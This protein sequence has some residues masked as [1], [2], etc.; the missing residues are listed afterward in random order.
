[1]DTRGGIWRMVVAMCMS[2]TIGFFVLKSGQAVGTVVF[3]RCLIGALGLLTWLA[4]GRGFKPLTARDI[5]WIIAGGIALILNWFCLF[6]AYR[7]SSISIATVVYHVQPFFLILLVALFQNQRPDWRKMPLL[8][9]AFIGVAFTA[10]LSSDPGNTSA[11][12]GIVLAL[13]AAFLYALTTLATRQLIGI[14]PAQIAGLQLLIG[15]VA[16]APFVHFA[17]GQPTWPA[18]SCLLALGLVHTGLLYNLMYAAFQRLSAGTIAAL[19]FIYPLVAIVIDLVV[20]DV[21][22]SVLQMVGMG[23]IL[24]A[25]VAYQQP[26]DFWKLRSQR[27]LQR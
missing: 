19:S 4:I 14:P 12:P 6:T 15:I 16:L 10:G 26:A 13:L 22:L 27:L 11:L 18:A 17:A 23:L 9:L 5:A 1:M 25:V 20:F 8:G 21:R 24:L 7:L 2:G 3:A